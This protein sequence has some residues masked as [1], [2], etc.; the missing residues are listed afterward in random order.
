VSTVAQD[1]AVLFTNLI[2]IALSV[3][4]GTAPMASAVNALETDEYFTSL[5]VEISGDYANYNFVQTNEHR[6]SV[7]FSLNNAMDIWVMRR[8]N[9]FVFG[10]PV[11]Q[12]ARRTANHL[13]TIDDG[14]QFV[15]AHVPYLKP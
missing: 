15:I 5:S 4:G 6:G 10:S 14:A 2:K 11:R 1:Q 3:L 9:Q 8:F 13:V 7:R 12:F